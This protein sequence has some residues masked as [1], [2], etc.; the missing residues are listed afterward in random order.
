M[1]DMIEKVARAVGEA[2]H[3]KPESTGLANSRE[4]FWSPE[5]R[6]A[7]EAMRECTDEMLIAAHSTIFQKEKWRRMIDAALGKDGK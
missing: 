1:T 4:E 3:N 6:A 7:I 2:F 5:A